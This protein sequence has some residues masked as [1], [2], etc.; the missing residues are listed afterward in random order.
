MHDRYLEG[1][2]HLAALLVG[3]GMDVEHLRLFERPR[4]DEVVVDGH[5]QFSRDPDMVLEQPVQ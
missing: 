2:H 5:V 4:G 3:L 1:V